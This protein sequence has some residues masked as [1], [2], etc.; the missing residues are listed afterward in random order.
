VRGLFDPWHLPAARRRTAVR[1]EQT[2]RPAQTPRVSSHASGAGSI[3]GGTAISLIRAKTSE[4]IFQRFF[5]LDR[6]S[7]RRGRR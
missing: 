4:K 3:K 2:L 1:A 7:G 5:Y 6:G